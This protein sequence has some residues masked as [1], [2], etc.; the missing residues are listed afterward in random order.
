MIKIISKVLATRLQCYMDSLINPFQAAFIK[1]RSILD[2]FFT[3]HFLSHHL[4]ST[5]QAALLKIDFERAFDHV[6]WC[7]LVDLLKARGFGARWIGWIE[8]LLQSSST[9]MLLNRVPGKCFPCRR[10]LRQGDPLSPLLFILCI[11]V[12]Y[13][14][15]QAVFD[16]LAIPGVGIGDVKIQTLQFAD[17][18]L[19]LFDGSSRSAGAI[20]LTLDTFS[21]HSGLKINYDKSS[22][23]PIN[24]PTDRASALASS[25]GCSLTGFPFNYLGLPLYPKALRRADYLPLI[26]RLDHRLAGWKALSLSRGGGGLFYL[27]RFSL[28]P[29]LISA[30]F[31]SSRF[32]WQTLSIR[33][34]GVSFGR[35]RDFP[36]DFTALL[37]GGTCA[38]PNGLEG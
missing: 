23:I 22:I 29:Q 16:S 14:M 9:A 37:S 20:K 24:L 11:D 1:G 38:D 6:N 34:G 19:I 21:L 27:T 8:S 10:G 15:L 18:L 25:F 13:R 33:F 35:A 31:L 32:G 28:A 26:E 7:F 4:H 36:T 17:D 5:N 2:N 3:A 12:L 30:Q